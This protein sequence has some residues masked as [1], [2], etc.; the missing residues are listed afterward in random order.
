MLKAFFNVINTPVRIKFEYLLVYLTLLFK[1]GFF[2]NENISAITSFLL[3]CLLL[4]YV[5]LYRIKVNLKAIILVLITVLF[6]TITN[7]LKG[8]TDTIVYSH[9]LVNLF[10]SGLI[11]SC[12]SYSKFS[13]YFSNIIYLV[14]FV[15][16]IVYLLTTLGLNI[17][18]LFPVLTNSQ[19][20]SCHFLGLTVSSVFSTNNRIQGIFWEPGAFQVMIIIAMI[21]DNYSDFTN[22]KLLQRYLIYIL[23]IIFTYST[24]GYIS[25]LL[26]CIL[27]M[28]HRTKYS[29]LPI[30]VFCLFLIFLIPF[31]Q[32]STDGFL[33][34]SIFGK[35]EEVQSNLMYGDDN[36]SETVYT[37]TGSIIYPLKLLK[38]SPIFGIGESG[39]DFIRIRY[40]QTL[41]TCTFV[42]YFAYYGIVLGLVHIIGFL[43]LLRLKDK[44]YIEGFL[45]ILTLILAT[46]SE[47]LQFNVLLVCFCIYGYLLKDDLTVYRNRKSY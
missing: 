20:V 1:L 38:E 18:K 16:L 46:M 25:L 26:V 36:V 23:A 4:V 47:A 28:L 41:F 22:K 29:I 15:S 6:V 14:S 11:V 35:L 45:L 39:K 8:F 24:T 34:Y 2:F 7:L 42:N 5:L 32:T 40:G 3:I 43:K 30:V 31:L 12:I 17:D 44:K 19:G 13:K 21:I 27:F 10:T 37:R 9:L 33:Y